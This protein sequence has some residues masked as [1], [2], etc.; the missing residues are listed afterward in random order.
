MLLKKIENNEIV[1]K[2]IVKI[3][4]LT[5][6]TKL[7]KE[8]ITPDLMKRFVEELVLEKSSKIEVPQ[9]K[10]SITRNHD[11]QNEE[12]LKRYRNDSFDKRIVNSKYSNKKTYAI[13]F[14]SVSWNEIK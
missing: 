4:G 2:K 12:L 13:G 6:V 5:I 3:R 1:T 10:I 7:Q 8:T 11:L 14:T 9:F